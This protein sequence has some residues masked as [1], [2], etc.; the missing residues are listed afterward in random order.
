LVQIQQ[1]QINQQQEQITQQQE[2]INKLLK[3]VE[4]LEGEANNELSFI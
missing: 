2:Q 1:K 3:R 4:L